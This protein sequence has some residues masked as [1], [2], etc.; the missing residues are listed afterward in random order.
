[1]FLAAV[2]EEI[3]MLFYVLHSKKW[4]SIFVLMFLMVRNGESDMLLC[5]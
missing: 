5:S 3:R 4:A 2:N 1:M